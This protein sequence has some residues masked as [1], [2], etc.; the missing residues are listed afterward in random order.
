MV[1]SCNC[2]GGGSVGTAG[3]GLS[4]YIFVQPPWAGAVACV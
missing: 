2:K 4:S 1:F 3:D